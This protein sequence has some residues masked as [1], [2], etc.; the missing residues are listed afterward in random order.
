MDVKPAQ[1]SLLWGDSILYQI[2]K[3]LLEM[4][5]MNMIFD[6]NTERKAAL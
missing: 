4:Q 5:G 6:R 2:P 1:K 3:V